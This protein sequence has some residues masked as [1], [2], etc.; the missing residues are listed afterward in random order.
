MLREIERSGAVAR[1]ANRRLT[2]GTQLPELTVVKRIGT[3]EDG[4]PLASPVAWTGP[5]PAPLMRLA[6]EGVEALP[7]GA[8][9]AARLVTLD[10]GEIEARVIRRLDPSGERVVGVFERDREGG[11]VVPADRRNRIEY[12]IAERD[13]SDAGNGELVIAEVLPKARFGLPEG[14]HRRAARADATPAQSACWRSLPSGIPH[15]FPAPRRS[16]RPKG[17][18][19]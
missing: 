10:T 16:P 9:A 11:R 5:E 1:A 8:R 7:L 3:D 14:A 15:E 13:T 19:R 6:D 18:H 2:G 17:R 12:R 4:V